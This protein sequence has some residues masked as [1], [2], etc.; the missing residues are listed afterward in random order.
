MKKNLKVM[1]ALLFVGVA[2]GA[3]EFYDFY[4]TDVPKM[5]RERAQ[6]ES[7]IAN[8]QA[9][10]KRLEAFA[11]NIQAVKQE[12]SELN[13]QLDSALEHMPRTFNFASLLRKMT[14]LAHNSGVEISVFK[15][16][17]GE[18]KQPN[19]FYSTL[20][21][22]FQIRGTFTQML[23]FFDQ[24]SRLKRIINVDTIKFK[25]GTTMSLRAGSVVAE[26]DV[27]IKTFRF[28]E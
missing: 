15:P 14:M 19:Q 23:V 11:Q 3:Y 17:P 25:P 21:I 24:L 2:L 4:S 1:I 27:S 10:L 20:S 16:K 5:T 22:D 8:E 6:Q 28:S 26:S 13:L 18:E 9:E 7:R 12:F